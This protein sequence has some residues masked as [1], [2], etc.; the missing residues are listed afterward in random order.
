MRGRGGGGWE[1]GGETLTL[2]SLSPSLAH[3]P[4]LP[5]T[6]FTQ[7]P[8]LVSHPPSLSPSL[9]PFLSPSLLAS[10]PLTLSVDDLFPFL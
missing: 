5:F 2:Y 7:N 3:T 8:G 6:L 10:H 9:P 4:S 1:G